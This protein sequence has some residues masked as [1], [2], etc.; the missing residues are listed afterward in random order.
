MQT[1]TI[2]TTAHA[3]SVFRDHTDGGH[4]DHQ[5]STYHTDHIDTSSY[6]DHLDNGHR[7]HT[8]GAF[9]HK[10]SQAYVDHSDANHRRPQRLRPF[11]H[12]D[13]LDAPY[14]DHLDAYHRG[15]RTMATL[16]S[17]RSPRQPLLGSSRQRPSGSH[18]CRLSGLDWHKF[19]SDHTDVVHNDH[20]RRRCTSTHTPTAPR[21]TSTL[22]LTSTVTASAHPGTWIS[23]AHTDM[24]HCDVDH[25][26]SHG[27]TGRVGT[28]EHVDTHGD[29]TRMMPAVHRRRLRV[30]TR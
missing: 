15:P 19:P 30:W 28:A 6:S 5:D 18:R 7:D 21:R 23:T 25:V 1:T 26:D 22:I 24:R 3:D 14:S 13:H 27:D 10:D 29:S 16:R 17:S 20:M 8:D 4:A 12:R 11:R 2:M 9:G